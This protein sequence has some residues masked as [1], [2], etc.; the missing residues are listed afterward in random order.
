[1]AAV[2]GGLVAL[3]G[4]AGQLDRRRR[5]RVF[6]LNQ[7]LDPVRALGWRDFE[8]WVAEAYRRKASR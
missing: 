4:L 1:V 6:G 8:R 5:R 3:L 2:A 7:D